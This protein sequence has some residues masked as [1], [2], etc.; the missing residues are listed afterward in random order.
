M[1]IAGRRLEAPSACPKMSRRSPEDGEIVDYDAEAERAIADYAERGVGEDLALRT[2][3]QRLLGG[4]PK[5]VLHGG[6]TPGKTRMRDV[7][8]EEV[9][10]LASRA[11]APTSP[12]SQPAAGGAARAAAAPARPRRAGDEDMVNV[13]REPLDSGAP[14]RSRR[15]CVPSCHNCRPHAC[16]RRVIADQPDARVC[17]RIY[18]DRLA[19]VPIS[20]RASGSP[21]R[22]PRPSTPIRAEGLMLI[23]HGIFS[24]AT[25]HEAMSG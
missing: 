14:P 11:A 22:R 9:R 20:C 19:C 8:G 3:R 2:I 25:A 7:Y 10:V 1:G 16:G 12:S 17:R 18:A 13:Q 23:K 4:D 21:R 24:F 6:K 5:L 15:C